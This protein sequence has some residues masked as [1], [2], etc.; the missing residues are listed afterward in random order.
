MVAS[1]MACSMSGASEQ[2]SK[3]R[4]KTVLV[5]DPIGRISMAGRL[6]LVRPHLRPGRLAAG[7]GRHVV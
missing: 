2:A 1:T 7:D 6:G 3:S 5:E 4:L